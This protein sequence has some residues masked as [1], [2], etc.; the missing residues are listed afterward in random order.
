M[1]FSVHIC[2]VYWLAECFIQKKE[3]NILFGIIYT[4]QP[5]YNTVRYN[6]ILDITQF[7]E[8]SQKCIDYIEKWP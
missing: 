8:G 6:T 5:P 1:Q 4:L 2:C 3:N 7:K